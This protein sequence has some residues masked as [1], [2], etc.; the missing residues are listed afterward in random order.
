M[1]VYKSASR[2]F[3]G[4]V[5]STTL[6]FMFCIP[7]TRRLKNRRVQNSSQRG[8]DMKK[9]RGVLIGLLC[10]AA[11]IVLIVLLGSLCAALVSLYGRIRALETIQRGQMKLPAVTVSFPASYG[12]THSF[13]MCGAI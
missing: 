4:Y 13:L 2:F 9:F 8:E 3:P 6:F 7:E 1:W 5:R 11:V 12:R 10:V